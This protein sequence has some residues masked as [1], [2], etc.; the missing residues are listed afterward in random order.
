MYQKILVPL[1]SLELSEAVLSH[2][3]EIATHAQAEIVLGRVPL[4]V[5]Q[6]PAVVVPPV[7][8]SMLMSTHGH[9]RVARWLLGS[10]TD[11]IAHGSQ[12]PA[13]LIRPRKEHQT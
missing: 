2:T 3:R 7:N 10:V 13:L 11:D 8:V 6:A 9:S 5:L 12:V 4:N 1:A